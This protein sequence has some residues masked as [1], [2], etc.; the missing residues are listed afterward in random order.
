M[1]DA[2]I[3]TM[4]TTLGDYWASQSAGQVA[5]ISRPAAVQRIVSANACDPEAVWDEAAALFETDPIWYWGYSSGDHLVV[6]AP[7]ACGG[8]TGLG[9]VGSVNAGGLI[10]ADYFEVLATSTMAHEFGHNLGLRHS[11]SSECT[12]STVEGSACADIPYEDFYDIMGGG[13]FYTDE[14]GAYKSNEQL[15]ALNVTQKRRLGALT[16]A[17]LPSVALAAGVTSSNSG[18]TLMPASAASGLRGL[19]VTDPRTGNAYFVEYRSGTG[20]DA[21]SIYASGLDSKLGLGVRVLQLRADGTSAVLTRPDALDPTTR[22]LFMTATQSFTSASGGLEVAV[23]GTGV[24]AAITVTLVALE[25]LTSTPV[26]TVSGTAKVGYALAA[27]SETWGPGTVTLGH[28]WYRSGVSIAG[29]TA[30]TYRLSAADVGKSMTVKVT[31]SQTGFESA[32]KTSAATAA[33]AAGTLST[34]TPTITGTKKVGYTLTANPGTWGPAAVTMKYQWYRSKIAITGATAKTYKL[35]AADLAKTMTVKATGSKTG[36]TG[37]S[38][39]SAATAAVVKGTLTAPTPTISGTR[40]VGYTLT[41]NPG[42]WGPA[43]V[44]LTYRW[45]RSGVAI[46][47]ATAKTYK[48]VSADRYDTIKVRVLGAKSGYAS[49]AKY[50]TSTA[51]VV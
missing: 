51:K 11:N 3:D 49:V 38:K 27:D 13:L 15:M 33:V 45:Y 17:D 22:P 21:G 40:K 14:S 42:T 50:S 37:A 23:T 41:A 7:E 24:T 35:A 20:M 8:G 46:P 31:G 29:A 26:P 25:K 39:L 43:T 34:V 9:T 36:Y 47:Y 16:A 1:S 30:T 18:F 32:S 48:L 5:S 44:K 6:I 28:Q 2:E 4:T 12:D 10:W 19:E